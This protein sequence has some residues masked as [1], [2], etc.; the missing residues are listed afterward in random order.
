[1][2]RRSA[3]AFCVAKRRAVLAIFYVYILQSI[4]NPEHF[5]TGYTNN[6]KLRI[7][8]HN[9]GDARHTNKY[10]PWKIRCYF[11]FDSADKAESFEKYLKT[12]AGRRFQK[13]HL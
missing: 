7:Q 13:K 10:R 11:A 6:L 12:H 5:Y 1:M 2:P 8:E 4:N 9:S 3:S